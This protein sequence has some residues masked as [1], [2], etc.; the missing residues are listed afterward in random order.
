MTKN[1]RLHRI[2][3]LSGASLATALALSL[4]AMVA[5]KTTAIIV[6]VVIMWL[7]VWRIVGNN[8]KEAASVKAQLEA[9]RADCI[10]TEEVR[11][12]LNLSNQLAACNAMAFTEA[13]AQAIRSSNSKFP[14]SFTKSPRAFSATMNAAFAT[15]EPAPA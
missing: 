12:A 9:S 2:L 7:S 10:R 4:I 3:I 14:F 13:Q 8:R 6:L 15:C 1:G 5:G 11:A